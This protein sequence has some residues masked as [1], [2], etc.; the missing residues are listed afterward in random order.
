M[1]VKY[2]V[3]IMVGVVIIGCIANLSKLK[4]SFAESPLS[5]LYLKYV[6]DGKDFDADHVI[7][8]L[9][10]KMQ[11][12]LNKHDKCVCRFTRL[13]GHWDSSEKAV[14]RKIIK[15]GMH[16]VE[17]GAN[18]GTHTL[19]MAGLLG[20]NGKL[21]AI[22]AN[23]KVSKYLVQS[24]QL[25]KLENNVQV[26]EFAVADKNFDTVMAYEE[27]NMGAG[28]ILSSDKDPAMVCS[29]PNIHCV[30]IKVRKLDELVNDKKI[31]IL[32]MDAEGSE[33]WILNGAE[34]ILSNPDITVMMEWGMYV[35]ERSGISP[36]EF[37]KK[38]HDY[39]FNIWTIGKKGVLTR[40]SYEQLP[41]IEFSDL[42][43]SRNPEKFA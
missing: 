39:G 10:N 43:L 24:V 21:I 18:Y 42:V 19:D 22:E 5:D 32:K 20:K 27:V 30:D 25:N 6:R 1:K 26:L 15:P 16:V 31:D 12:I 9:D 4:Q 13:A 23:P 8:T 41:S 11:I 17:V 33:Y 29:A 37:A 36:I 40:I 3:T 35:I 34:N 14:L 2:V 38:L 7:T 28:Y